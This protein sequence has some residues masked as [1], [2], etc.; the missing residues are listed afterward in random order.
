MTDKT[1]ITDVIDSSCKC[2][3]QDLKQIIPVPKLLKECYR[4]DYGHPE[5][6]CECGR[7]LL[8]PIITLVDEK[9]LT[10]IRKM[11]NDK[12]AEAEEKKE[13]V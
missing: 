10:I 3:Y 8:I 2:P 1:D 7:N 13:N 5:H 12:A 11:S 9:K 4:C 6:E